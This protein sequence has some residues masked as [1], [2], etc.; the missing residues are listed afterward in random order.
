M[1]AQTVQLALLEID[2]FD[3]LPTLDEIPQAIEPELPP[4]TFIC[5]DCAPD[6]IY[7]I[8]EIADEH[9]ECDKCNKPTHLWYDETWLKHIV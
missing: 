8:S 6:H 5:E 2:V 9:S 7:K 4:I 1:S 3:P